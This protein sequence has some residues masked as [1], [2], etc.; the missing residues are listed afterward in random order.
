MIKDVLSSLDG[1]EIYP[2]IGMIFFIL[3][4]AG[5]IIRVMKIDK[6]EIERMSNLP[7]ENGDTINDFKGNTNE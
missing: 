4:F 3:V 1:I 6:K 5:S 7:L 2:I